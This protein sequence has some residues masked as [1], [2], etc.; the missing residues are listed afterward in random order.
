[1]E[2]LFLFDSLLTLTFQSMTKTL[3]QAL[4]ELKEIN[5]MLSQ[6]K[7]SHKTKAVLFLSLF[8]IWEFSLI[9]TSFR[10]LST[11]KSLIK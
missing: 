11:S 6:H 3:K 8:P 2:L 4:K 5:A 7:A 9:N 1:M 10:C